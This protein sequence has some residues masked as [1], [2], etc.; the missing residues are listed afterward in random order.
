MSSKA[1]WYYE[2]VG[3]V[4]VGTQR[5]VM[6]HYREDPRAILSQATHLDWLQ[7]GSVLLLREAETGGF[8]RPVVPVGCVSMLEAGSES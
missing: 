5:Q 8:P 4:L 6:S 3:R 2:A 7:E 1:S